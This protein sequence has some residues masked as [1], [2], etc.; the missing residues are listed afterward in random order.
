MLVPS[1]FALADA[2][3]VRLTL[4]SIWSSPSDRAWLDAA[5][6]VD[7]SMWLNRAEL[8]ALVTLTTWDPPCAVVEALAILS[9]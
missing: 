2:V 7:D 6:D 9:V 5:S 3:A 4:F 8:D 1:V